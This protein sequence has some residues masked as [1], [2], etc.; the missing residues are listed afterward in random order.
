MSLESIWEGEGS[1]EAKPEELPKGSMSIDPRQTGRYDEKK[2][3]L[4]FCS[5]DI[6]AV[7]QSAVKW[8]FCSCLKL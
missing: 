6:L 3:V 1:H 2:V 7:L 4:P 5:E 8:L